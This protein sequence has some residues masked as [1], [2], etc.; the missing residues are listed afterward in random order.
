M[1]PRT[2]LCEGCSRTIGEITAWAQLDNEGRRRVL[3][4]VEQRR[5]ALA[6]DRTAST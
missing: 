6:P 5:A 2:G 1:N 4:V 3:H